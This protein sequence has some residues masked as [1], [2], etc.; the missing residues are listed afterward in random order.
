MAA[1]PR[2]GVLCAVLLAGLMAFSS[3]REGVGA[4]EAP[5]SMPSL[6]A[7][8]SVR[9]AGGSG[10]LHTLQQR[11]GAGV[12]RQYGDVTSY[13]VARLHIGWYMDWGYTADP[14][15]PGGIEY[16]QLVPTAPSSF[17]PDWQSLSLA[18]QSNPGAMWLIG[19]EPDASP[20]VMDSQPPAS[21]AS[22]Y[23]DVYTHIK[24]VDPSALVGPG[25]VIEPTPLRLRYLDMVLAAYQA[26]YGVALPADFWATHVQ[27]LPEVRAD[28]GAG[29]PQGIAEDSGRIYTIQDNA[30]PAIFRQMVRDM[31]QWMQLRGL[32]DMPLII[33]EYGVLMPS[34]YLCYCAERASGDQMV[35]DFMTSSFDF[36][37]SAADEQTGY[38]R[39]S[40]RLV[41]RWSWYS[42]N[43]KPYDVAP[44]GVG[45]NGGL[46]DWR[47]RQFPGALTVFGQAFAAY[48]FPLTSAG[49]SYLPAIVQGP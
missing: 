7:H 49:R 18:V 39:D 19:N 27:I 20:G 16:V 11:F 29:I 42:L 3:A 14:P 26:Q 25:G 34:L 44:W 31:R 33:S 45:Y 43:E 38:A 15:R 41:Q 10:A 9:G 46:F 22:A 47:V 30:G 4:E 17:P 5:G 6:Q 8:A 2:A 21:Y 48:T 24:V 12:A 28:W 35:I 1:L 37:L 13:D 40:N 36:L 23:H 32:R